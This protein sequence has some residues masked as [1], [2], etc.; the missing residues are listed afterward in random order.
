MDIFLKAMT[1]RGLG[2]ERYIKGS[3]CKS[4]KWRPTPVHVVVSLEWHGQRYP[5]VLFVQHH[6]PYKST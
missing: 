5:A 6:H 2:G 3:K 4:W 1:A